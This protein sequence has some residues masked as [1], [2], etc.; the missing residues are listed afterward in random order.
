MSHGEVI[1]GLTGFPENG[2]F[3]FLFE[4]FVQYHTIFTECSTGSYSMI[5]W[6]I[7]T[8]RFHDCEW[9]F[10]KKKSMSTSKHD[11][12]GT[13]K[14]KMQW[15]SGKNHYLGRCDHICTAIEAES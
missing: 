4:M 11:I 13:R 7:T 12:D 15:S 3:L 1:D 2:A 5:L 9:I 8:G 6:P 10:T 14:R